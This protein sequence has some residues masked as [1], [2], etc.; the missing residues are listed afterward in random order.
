M[1]LLENYISNLRTKNFVSEDEESKLTFLEYC[2]ETSTANF[3]L[4]RDCEQFK[5]AMGNHNFRESILFAQK[6]SLQHQSSLKSFLQLTNTNNIDIC[7]LKGAFMANFAYPNFTMRT[8]RDI[9]VLVEEAYF[10]KI[11]NIMLLN[12]YSFLNTKINKL[13]KFN[14]SYSHQAPILVDKFG[15]AFEIH[16]RL[17]RHSEFKNSDHLAKN[18]MQSKKEKFFCDLAVSI[19]SEN[20][21][22]IH[23]C[24]HAIGKSKLNIGPIF[25]NDLLQFKN[26]NDHEVLED[27]KRANCIKE[28]NLG[29]SLLRYLK[30]HDVANEKHVKD[31]LEIII[32]CH[33]MP[34]L[35]PRKSFN[36]LSSVKDS[37][38][39][40]SF[41]L[42]IN[43]FLIFKLK[44]I[45]MFCKSYSLKFNLHKKRRRFFKGFSNKEF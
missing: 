31:A 19:P 6:K 4:G 24:Y 10:L 8:M 16:H 29:I 21:A 45:F 11:V 17:K 38:A 42:S 3:F 13:D 28:V 25:L 36:F 1:S 22:F 35:F 12:G 30:G 44:Q 26:I 40:N 15:T 2:I 33:N 41:A 9:D 5:S 18:L 27:A 32:Y 37:Y 34:E 7:L 23:C 20:Y 39:H 14:F 43:N